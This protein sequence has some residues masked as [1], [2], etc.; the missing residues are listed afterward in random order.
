MVEIY[1]TSLA[2]NKASVH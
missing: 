1:K 2:S